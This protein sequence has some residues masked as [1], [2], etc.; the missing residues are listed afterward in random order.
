VVHFCYRHGTD[1]FAKVKSMITGMLKKL[2]EK[3]A[4]EARHAEWCDHE[5]G[6]PTKAQKT[7]GEDV[8]KLKDRL[9]ALDADLTQISADIVTRTKDLQDINEA[10]A[11]ALKIRGKEHKVA[12]SSIK[13]YKDA[14]ALLERACKVL[15][16]YYKNKAGGG[17]EVKKDEFKQRHGL[18]TGIIGILEIAIDDFKKLHAETKEAEEAAAKDFT[19]TQNE[20]QIRAAVFQKDLE[21]KSRTKVKLE[22]DQATMSNDL[23]SYQKELTAID[24]YME[25]LKTSCSVKGPSY[26]E[27]KERRDNELKSLKEALTYLKGQGVSR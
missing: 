17:S 18:G 26:E 21:W 15:K 9:D 14:A 11:A 10:V 8:Q 12:T 25:K 3:Q 16:N 6:K 19:E 1:P 4:Q 5:M 2:K 24:G 13:Q 23:K 27:K 20:S 7:K 22:F